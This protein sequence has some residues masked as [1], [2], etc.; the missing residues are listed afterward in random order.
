MQNP[1]EPRWNNVPKRLLF[2]IREG[3]PLAGRKM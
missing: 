1:N 3:M 2:Q